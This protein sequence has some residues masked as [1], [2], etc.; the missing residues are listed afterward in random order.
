MGSGVEHRSV[1]A[2]SPANP[3]ITEPKRSANRQMRRPVEKARLIRGG[4]RCT[5]NLHHRSPPSLPHGTDRCMAAK[6]LDA[7]PTELV[8]GGNRSQFSI[9]AFCHASPFCKAIDVPTLRSSNFKVQP[10]N[11]G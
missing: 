7:S 11:Y 6:R 3:A 10:S 8:S 2:T 9:F 1:T 5:H 4:L